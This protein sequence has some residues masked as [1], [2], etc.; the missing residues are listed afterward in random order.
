MDKKII[1][2]IDIGSRSIELVVL[3]GD[4]RIHEAKAPTTFDPLGQCRKIMEVSPWTGS[5][6]GISVPVSYG[7]TWSYCWLI[8]GLEE[9]GI[10]VAPRSPDPLTAAVKSR[11]TPDRGVRRHRVCQEDCTGIKS[12][13]RII[14]ETDADP[15]RA[16]ARHYLQ[17]P[18]S[19]LTQQGHDLNSSVD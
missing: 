18:C 6:P 14:D 2:G 16:M 15:Y 5:W 11:V 4:Q 7:R 10:S 9:T 1:A 17:T 3:Q 8:A 13:D 19:C 12:F